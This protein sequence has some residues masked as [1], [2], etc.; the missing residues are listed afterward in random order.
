MIW[1]RRWTVEHW[2]WMTAGLGHVCWMNWSRTDERSRET[3]T[4][5]R[6]GRHRFFVLFLLDLFLWWRWNGNWLRDLSLT[7]R[8]TERRWAIDA[9]RV[10]IVM[11]L[12][13]ILMAIRHS[14]QL[15]MWSIP[16]FVI[17]ITVVEW[18]F[19]IV[20]H[21]QI[22]ATGVNCGERSEREENLWWTWS[23]GNFYF[24]KRV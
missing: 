2:R 10:E 8:T 17:L 20:C 13:T 23:I 5:E 4:A 16:Y 11:T 24:E 21:V 12:I 7:T 14:V 22:T 9:I 3:L 15:L 1:R 19:T 6:F 18:T